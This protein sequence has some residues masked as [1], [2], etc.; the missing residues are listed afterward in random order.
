MVDAS[1]PG[2]ATC[3]DPWAVKIDHDHLTGLVRGYLCGSCNTVVD[4]CRHLCGCRFADYLA[5]PPALPLRLVYP[6]WRAQ[7][8]SHRYEVRRRRFQELLIQTGSEYTA[9]LGG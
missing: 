1:G 3:A 9:F 5:N 8:Q 2:C 7:F 6:R 4:L